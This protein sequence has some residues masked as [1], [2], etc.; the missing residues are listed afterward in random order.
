M[1]ANLQ[2]HPFARSP[3]I[4]YI[5]VAKGGKRNLN[6][7]ILVG[8]LAQDPSCEE[9]EN[10]K[11]R[12]IINIAVPRNFK[13]SEGIYE[14]DFIRCVLWNG[15]AQNVANYCKVGDSIAVRGRIQTITYKDEQGNQKYLTEVI[16]QSISFVSS[17]R[18]EMKNEE[19]EQNTGNVS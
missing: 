2:N 7:V 15:I 16:A 10:N 4:R 14:S 17:S 6:N 19:V 5:H 3:K 8:R 9:L 12:A 11:K 1:I 13:N 18:K